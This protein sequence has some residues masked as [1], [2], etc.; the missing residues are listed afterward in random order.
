MGV[1]ARPLP[2]KTIMR[3]LGFTAENV[4]AKALA[5]VERLGGV[6]A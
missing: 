6:R 4:A 5:L 1:S 2:Y 3:E